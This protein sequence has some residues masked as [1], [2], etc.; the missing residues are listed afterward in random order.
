MDKNLRIKSHCFNKKSYFKKGN[1]FFYAYVV[2]E[3][4]KMDKLKSINEHSE[5][6]KNLC[7]WLEKEERLTPDCEKAYYT[8]VSELCKERATIYWRQMQE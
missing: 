1:H 2:Y 5:N 7:L 3:V 8:L 6:L 4:I